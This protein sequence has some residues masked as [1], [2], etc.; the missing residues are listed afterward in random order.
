MTAE[1]KESLE[2]RA[3]NMLYEDEDFVVKK[4]TNK[5]SHQVNAS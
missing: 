2:E 4:K 1:E 5:N 3:G